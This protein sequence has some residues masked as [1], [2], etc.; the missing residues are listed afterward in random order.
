M[1]SVYTL[2]ARTCEQDSARPRLTWYDDATGERIELSGATLMNWVNKTANFMIDELLVEPGVSIGL[3]LPRHWL[4]A[5]WWLAAHAADASPRITDRPDQHDIFVVGPEAISPAAIT[6][7]QTTS[8]HV[9]AVALTPLA[10]GFAQDLPEA[11]IDFE[12]EVR[13]QP[14]AFVPS[15]EQ[16][17]GTGSG[18]ATVDVA[19]EGSEQAARWGLTSNDRLLAAGPLADNDLVPQ[20]LAPL[21]VGGSCVWVRNPDPQ[22]SVQRLA[23]EHITVTVADPADFPHPAESD[24]PPIRYLT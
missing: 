6:A 24:G 11:V 3:D 14:D 23:T 12:R 7:A 13:T 1:P 2:L 16:S 5:V 20:L 10:T 4:T 21:A 19:V 9:V 8:G 18:Q 15:H 17:T 22:I